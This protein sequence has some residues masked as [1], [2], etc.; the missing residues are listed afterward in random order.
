MMRRCHFIKR[1]LGKL[2][3]CEKPV[4]QAFE[5]YVLQVVEYELQ[6]SSWVLEDLISVFLEDVVT[7]CI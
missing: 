2:R 5:K 3:K 4:V 1:D 6:K 7:E